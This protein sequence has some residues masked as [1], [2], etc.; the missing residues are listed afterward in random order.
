MQYKR[1]IGKIG[2]TVEV[3]RVHPKR[4]PGLT[5]RNIL[6]E[7][8]TIPVNLDLLGFSIFTYS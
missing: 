2:G 3:P 4:F 5:S 7:E 6:V 1:P 8:E